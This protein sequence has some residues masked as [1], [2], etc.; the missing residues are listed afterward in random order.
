[1]NRQ[2]FINKLEQLNLPRSEYIILSGG[3]LLMRGLRDQ[4]ADLDITVSKKLAA[5]L[6]L[7]HCPKDSQGLYIPFENVQM[8]DDM[9]QFHYD[10]IDG[11]QC[12]SLEDILRQKR[13]WNRPKDRADIEVITAFLNKSLTEPPA[14]DK[15]DQP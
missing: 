2:E 1:M 9:E 7:Y 6:D 10:V 15:G 11:Y 8:K 4:T 12:E 5:E 14:I 13:E 3:S